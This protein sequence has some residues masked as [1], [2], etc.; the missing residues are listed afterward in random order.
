[1]RD[2]PPATPTIGHVPAY[3]ENL[4]G[5]RHTHQQRPSSWLLQSHPPSPG[6]W[7]D[8]S[9]SSPAP[10]GFRC[11]YEFP[12]WA[13]RIGHL[14]SREGTGPHRRP[15]ASHTEAPAKGRRRNGERQATGYPPW[16]H[17]R[18][19]A[20]GLACCRE[21]RPGAPAGNARRRA[22]AT[23]VLHR[24]PAVRPC[25]GF[26]RG[27]HRLYLAVRMFPVSLFLSRRAG[28]SSRTAALSRRLEAPFFPQRNRH[29]TVERLRSRGSVCQCAALPAVSYWR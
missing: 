12:I 29:L 27:R 9:P 14:P 5:H 24:L 26:R 17:A 15:A 22:L 10:N 11:R 28:V 8:P 13:A 21:H 2:D 6:P 23:T 1:V 7:A 25:A 19:P 20:V 16:G 3:P 4:G 18:L